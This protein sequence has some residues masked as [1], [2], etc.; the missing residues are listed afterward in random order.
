MSQFLR[1]YPNAYRLLLRMPK[2]IRFAFSPAQMESI[3]LAL[4]P[5]TH[6]V[7]V[8]FLLPLLGKGA[9]FVLSAGPNRRGQSRLDDGRSANAVLGELKNVIDM[10]Q[11]FRN[12]PNAYRMLQ[13]IPKEVITTFTP[14]QI[15]AME[16]ALVPRSHLIDIRLSLPLMGKGAY[17]VLAAGPNTRSHYNNIQNGNPFVMPTVF[18]SVTVAALS[19]AGLVQLKGSNLLKEEDPVFTQEKFHPT[20]VPFKKNRAECLE[21]GRRW[22]DNECIDQVHDPTF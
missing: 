9:Y 17:M 14:A 18:A 6:K 7:D 20:V 2:D 12:S 15:Q 11:A 8:R 3:E 22:V 1:H 5:R 13:R 16:A 21:S 19:I 10:N 4:V